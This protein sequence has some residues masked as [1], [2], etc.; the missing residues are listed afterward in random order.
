MRDTWRISGFGANSG[1][2]H[3]GRPNPRPC[4]LRQGD[5]LNRPNEPIAQSYVTRCVRI[6]FPRQVSLSPGPLLPF[7]RVP[8]TGRRIT[9]P[10]RISS[11]PRYLLEA[12]GV[13]WCTA[14]HMKQMSLYRAD[15]S[16]PFQGA[17]PTAMIADGRSGRG[18]TRPMRCVASMSNPSSSKR[19]LGSPPGWWSSAI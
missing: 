18:W 12:R 11:N 13:D 2:D 10:R 1:G 6:G 16:P 9:S 8:W 17:R 3:P 7:S 5:R 4:S 19:T 14:R 15:G